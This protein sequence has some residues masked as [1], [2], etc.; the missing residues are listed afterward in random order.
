MMEAETEEMQ[1]QAKECLGPPELKETEGPSPRAF[2]RALL[3]RGPQASGLPAVRAS[4]LWAEP[5]CSCPSSPGT[6]VQ[7][8]ERNLI[9]DL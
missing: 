2:R 6:G 1:P 7:P 4:L 5:S 9:W 3:T 8:P